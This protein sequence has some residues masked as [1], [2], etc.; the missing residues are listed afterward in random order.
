MYDFV[1]SPSLIN[2]ND[3]TVKIFENILDFLKIG[4]YAIF[5]TKLN[6]AKEDQYGKEINSLAE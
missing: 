2:N 5:A 6:Y 3:L 1:V 4:G